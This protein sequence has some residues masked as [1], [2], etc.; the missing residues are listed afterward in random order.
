MN[1]LYSGQSVFDAINGIR[2]PF[3]YYPLHEDL[4]PSKTNK[5]LPSLTESGSID[6]ATDPSWLTLDGSTSCATF[7]AYGGTGLQEVCELGDG[8]LMVWGQ[9][10]VPAGPDTQADRLIDIGAGGKGVWG[11]YFQRS[12]TALSG[13]ICTIYPSIGFDEDAAIVAYSPGGNKFAID[14][15]TVFTILIDNRPNIKMAWTYIDG[16]QVGIKTLAGKGSCTFGATLTKTA[17]LFA[18]SLGTP[19][20]YSLCS[21]RR[22]GIMNFGQDVP[23]NIN[24]IVQGLARTKGVPCYEMLEA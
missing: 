17:R 1:P 16:A 23:R 4:S 18:S 24:A 2:Y 12:S 15:P 14:A 7:S 8:C 20:N 22:L 13:T 11:V 5:T 3:V 6:F 19:S 9:I 21:V 10:K